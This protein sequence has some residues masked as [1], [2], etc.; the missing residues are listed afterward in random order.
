MNT[1]RR[2]KAR[3][4][5]FHTPGKPL[6]LCEFALP[7]LQAG[8]ALVEITCST[9]CGSDLHTIRGDR[10]VAGPTVLGHEMIGRIAELSASGSKL[11]DVAET[12]LEIGDRVTWSVA[13]SCGKCFFCD[14]GLPQKCEQL[15]K[16]GHETTNRSA[17]SGGLAKFCHLIRGTAIVKV[18]DSLSDHVA[19]PANCATA[20]VAAAVRTAG[21]CQD[22]TVVIHGAGMLGLTTAAM[23]ATQGAASVI[24]SDLSEQRLVRARDFGATNT[25]DVR[26]D[27][28]A[29]SEA[30]RDVTSGRGVDLIFEMSGAPFA[31][32]QSIELLR[33]GGQLVLVGS[34][35][36][37]RAAQML[38]EQIVRKLLRID[39][40]HNYTPA[41]LTAAIDFL[42][43]ASNTYPFESL[44]DVEF[45]LEDVNDGVDALAAKDAVRA[46]VRPQVGHTRRV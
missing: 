1:T 42:I 6:E 29:L 4:A 13:A 27:P 38:P 45:T 21:G 22:Q 11:C 36:P 40:V 19:C 12:P 32:E 44:V 24:V 31:I 3:A 26:E 35:F 41:N 33:V 23:A 15:F 34:V 20:T 9:I 2:S 28:S 5:V 25:V 37:T 18:P 30:T 10:P 14:H 46:A 8:E 43:K 7:V 39:G 16:Y 17:L